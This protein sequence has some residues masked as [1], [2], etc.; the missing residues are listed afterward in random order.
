MAVWTWPALS[1]NSLRFIL[2]EDTDRARPGMMRG[3]TW[4]DLRCRIHAATH[5]LELIGFPA[6]PHCGIRVARAGYN[7]WVGGHHFMHFIMFANKPP[8]ADDYSPPARPAALTGAIGGNMG[9]NT[10]ESCFVG[11]SS[12]SADNIL[13]GNPQFLIA[14]NPVGENLATPNG[15]IL[16]SLNP[17]HA[18][19]ITIDGGQGGDWRPVN[20]GLYTLKPEF[21]LHTGAPIY[22]WSKTW[23]RSEGDGIVV[24]G[25]RWSRWSD[26]QITPIIPTLSIDVNIAYARGTPDPTGDVPHNQSGPP[27]LT[28]LTRASGGGVPNG[29]LVGALRTLNRHSDG[30]LVDSI[31]GNLPF[32]GWVP[33][34]GAPSPVGENAEFTTSSDAILT[35]QWGMAV[36]P[37][38]PLTAASGTLTFDLNIGRHDASWNHELPPQ[39]PAQAVGRPFLGWSD[40]NGGTPLPNSTA[41]DFALAVPGPG[42]RDVHACWGPSGGTDPLPVLTRTGH[43]FLGWWTTSLPGTGTQVTTSSGITGNTTLFARWRRVVN[44]WRWGRTTFLSAAAGI[45]LDNPIQSRWELVLCGKKN[46]GGAWVNDIT[47]VKRA[48][49]TGWEDPYRDPSGIVIT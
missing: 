7:T 8:V 1:L 28:V 39:P 45:T 11:G 13:V 29:T 46:N 32:T 34:A 2:Q 42:A 31:N 25:H 20:A 23:R 36:V 26:S 14:N 18:G 5:Q 15:T 24:N 48:T 16:A 9:T 27:P 37:C 21:N 4:C 44:A 47:T 41:A 43:V 12:K 40:T 19:T 6:T 17:E 49:V 3:G 38:P 33:S 10:Y 35:A 22:I 30:A